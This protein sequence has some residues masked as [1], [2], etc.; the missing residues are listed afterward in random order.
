MIVSYAVSGFNA[1]AAARHYAN[2][3]P[4][5]RHP[6]DKV[7]ADGFHRVAENGS[8]Q[9]NK[10]SSGR[11]RNARTARVEESI[12]ELFRIDPTR[13]IRDVA[14]R[15]G[16][17]YGTVQRT[18]KAAGQHAYHYTRVQRLQLEDY[19]A[20]LQFCH[21]LIDAEEREP[22]CIDRIVFTNES[23]FGRNG[24]WNYH[25]FHSWSADNPDVTVERNAQHRFPSANLW[26]GMYCNRL[27][28]FGGFTVHL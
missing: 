12:L 19:P 17:S 14:R 10:K 9:P 5:R 18:M 15:L 27:V 25:N 13:S 2:R 4:D 28:N 11:P 24:V 22:G 1:V 21:F 6:S 23:S 16:T 20:R 3:W 26:A 8:V 7:I